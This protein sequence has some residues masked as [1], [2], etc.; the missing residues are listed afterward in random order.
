MEAGGFD[1]N[2]ANLKAVQVLRQ[3]TNTTEHFTLNLKAV[4]KGTDTRQFFL[5]PSDIIYVPE[6][7]SFF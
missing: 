3:E 2:T 7:F 6:R 4:M 1:Y 5:K